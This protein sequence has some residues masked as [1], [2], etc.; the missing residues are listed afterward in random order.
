MT[1]KQAEKE[2]EKLSKE[3]EKHNR[4]YH[5]LDKPIITDYEFDQLFQKLLELE[6]QFPRLIKPDS[7]SHK[8][9]GQPLDQ[10]EK[11]SHE[12][13]MLSLQNT[14]SPEEI[15]DFEQKIKRQLGTDED[16][17]YFCSP[18]Y[19]GVAIELI[20]N[21]GVLD[22][23]LTRGDGVT[24]ENVVSNVRTIRSLPLKLDL[25]DP[26]PRI[27]IR[28][29]ILLFKEDFALINGRQ[30]EEGQPAFA[31]PRNAAAGTL[32]QLD[33]KIAAG[34]NLRMFCYSCGF[35]EGIDFQ[36]HSDFESFLAKVGLPH[37]PFKLKGKPSKK[38]L[39]LVCRGAKEVIDYYKEIESLRHQLPFEIDGIV[40]KVNSY[41]MQQQLGNIARSPRWAFAAKFTPEQAKTKVMDIQVQVGRTGALTPVAIMEP[42]S[43]GGVTVT[44]ATLHNQDEINRKDVRVGDW[45][46]I[47][48]AGDVIPEVIEVI[49]EKRP[50][51]SKPFQIPDQCPVCKEKVTQLE[52]E[53][54]KRCM[55]HLC[56]AVIKES[57]KHFVSRNAMNIDKLGSRLIEVFYDEGMVQ[58]FSDLYRL[59]KDDIMALDRQGEKSAQNIISSIEKSKNTELHRFIFAMGIRF[60]GEQ[61]ARTLA[62][63]FKSMDQFLKT[64]KEE[65]VELPDVGPKVAESIM[66][67]LK[68]KPFHK[69]VAALIKLGIKTKS[70]KK[71]ATSGKLKDLS[72]VVTGTLPVSR[73]EVHD[74]IRTHGGTVVSSVSKNTSVLVAGEKAGSKLV[75][76]EKLRVEVWSWDDLQKK[77]S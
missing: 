75:K 67:T 23:A 19:D 34:R 24:G 72:F 15:E 20:Y 46:L 60:V 37:M 5:S 33:P 54:V 42:V 26:P 71:V 74:L 53:V 18:K 21:K 11:V 76:A 40:V 12:R 10:F 3:I 45:V 48:R 43:V 35:K 7:P 17:E 14:Y 28:G 63:H 77:L 65:L 41:P 57:L 32:R 31:N 8:V 2:I 59:T 58:S 27:D 52:G 55:N 68:Q 73:N 36:T 30:E 16:I 1:E 70:M 62:E 56:P 64:N 50:K 69:E 25:K 51:G 9:G 44:H 29:E 61:T 4:L 66:L 39:S 47:H 22:M 13:P 49:K 6:A 38:S